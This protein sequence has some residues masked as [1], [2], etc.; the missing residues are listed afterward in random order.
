MKYAVLLA[1]LGCTTAMRQQ[2]VAVTGRLMCGS[3]PAEGVKVKLW[4]EDDGKP[5]THLHHDSL[6]LSELQ[7]IHIAFRS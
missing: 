5:R 6:V 3:K 2:A 1:L 4:D 7:Y